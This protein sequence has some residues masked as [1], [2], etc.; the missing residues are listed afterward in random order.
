MI[1][2]TLLGLSIGLA[3]SPWI[4]VNLKRYAITQS[5]LWF[6][7]TFVSLDSSM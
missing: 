4:I 3:I 2:G 7:I 6:M 1:F 5:I